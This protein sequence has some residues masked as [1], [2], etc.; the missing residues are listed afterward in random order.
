M[1]SIPASLGIIVALPNEATVLTQESPKQHSPLNLSHN[2]TLVVCG[3]GSSNAEYA[4]QLLLEHGI[5]HL[6]SFGTAGGL[7]P[8]CSAGDVI[9]ANSCI[10]TDGKTVVIDKN[11]QQR[12]ISV[13]SQVKS[14][15]I[16]NAPICESALVVA[17][18]LDK[19]KLFESNNAAAVD[20]ESTILAKIAHQ[21]HI[22]FM[23]LRVIVDPA[24]M[25]IPLTVMNNM[26]QNGN[27]A[28]TKLMMGLITKPGD[29]LSLIYLAKNFTKARK[30]MMECKKIL[31]V[32]FLFSDT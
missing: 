9:I 11:W 29:I 14:L 28:I 1:P 21:N 7:N 17:N 26:D 22:P 23:S 25:A 4:A 12:I 32:D 10:D 27:V 5:S 2:V 16:I 18:V 30:A 20:M 24:D 31:G 8:D 13:L 19:K 3:M 15:N 6:L